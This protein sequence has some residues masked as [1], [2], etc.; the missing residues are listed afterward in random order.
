LPSLSAARRTGVVRTTGIFACAA[1]A[2]VIAGCEIFSFADRVPPGSGGSGGAAGGAGAT[3]GGS[4]G[5]TTSATGPAPECLT[6]LDCAGTGSDCVEPVCDDGRCGTRPADAGKPTSTQLA[7][8]CVRS[9]CDGEGGQTI[10][11]DD[12][13]VAI[14]GNGCTDDVCTAGAASN[15]ASAAGSPCAED[16]GAVCD[17]A[18]HCVE[19]VT[20]A[21]CGGGT[22][23]NNVCVSLTCI[24][25]VEDPGE[26]D[27]DCGGAACPPC[28]P[29]KKCVAG[30][31]CTSLV[32]SGNVCLPP[33]CGDKVKNGLETDVDCGGGDCPI[34][35]GAGRVCVVDADC[36]G[37][38]CDAG[39]C[40]PTCTDESKN[41]DE[42]GVD[43]GGSCPPCASGGACGWD[44]DCA[45]HVCAGGVC[46]TPPASC[47]DGAKDNGETDV[48]C[49]GGACR[50]CAV[51][52]VCSANGDCA[53]LRCEGGACGALVLLSE[54]RT[55]GQGGTHDELVELYN[56]LGVAVTLDAGWTLHVRSAI[57]ACASNAE[58]VLFT[59]SGQVIAPHGHLLLGGSAYTQSPTADAP[60][61]AAGLPDAGSL[62]I[63]QG[64]TVVDALCYAYDAA[65]RANL[66]SCQIGYVCEGEP[67]DNLPHDNTQSPA[68]TVD[69]SLSRKPGGAQGN[70]RDTGASSTDFEG[71][72]PAEPQGSASPATP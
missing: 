26:T 57:G 8:D 68:S 9:V 47:S 22:C 16:G 36:Q 1:L 65:T 37:D 33:S 27:V 54:V 63:R 52:A 70:Q 66:A 21:Q 71:I 59:G 35:C 5:A 25:S 58:K 24:N 29:G 51:G 46:V 44:G 60:L 72:A 53:S 61:G 48:D 41:L 28:A 4:A 14:D 55:R 19:C 2:V 56:P 62:V 17:G 10:V 49:G 31:D 13:D 6:A 64:T 69:A 39:V 38:V 7:G 20:A 32:C 15:P 43:C 12:L 50:G 23:A 40:A 18:G 11:P 34:G 45:S 30:G 3:V 67:A 42:T